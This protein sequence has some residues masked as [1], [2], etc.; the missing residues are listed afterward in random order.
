MI[1]LYSYHFRLEYY[2]ILLFFFS[3]RRRHTRFDCDWSSDVCS[4]DL[5]GRA[6]VFFSSRRRH[7]RFDCDW[8]PDVCS[9]DLLQPARLE[10]L[11]LGEHAPGVLQVPAHVA[12][13]HQV[14]VVAYDLAHGLDRAQV[15]AHAFLQMGRAVAEAHLEGLEAD[16]KSVV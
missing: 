8:S 16:R 6:H 4:S 13:Q 5:I 11:Q 10:L 3:S 1:L 15:L 9:S 2:L 14:A 7:M 12:L